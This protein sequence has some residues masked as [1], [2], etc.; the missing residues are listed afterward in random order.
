MSTMTLSMESEERERFDGHQDTSQPNLRAG[1][2][3]ERSWEVFEREAYLV[4]GIFGVSMLIDVFLSGFRDSNNS[5]GGGVLGLIGLIVYG[6]M[7]A[8]INHAL[9]RLMRKEKVEFERIFKG[10]FRFWPAAGVSILSWTFMA[11]GFVCLLVPGIIIG[12]GLIP[13]MY[14]VLEEHRGVKDTLSRAWSLTQGHKMS[15]GKLIAVLVIFNFGGLLLCGVGV[16]F[17]GAFSTLVFAAAYDEL[18]QSSVSSM[19]AIDDSY[20]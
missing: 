9:V 19:D 10:F 14:L 15:L 7:K 1:H 17:T 20:I 5:G 13:C 12:L 2:L 4:V 11:L 8:G 3:F 16:I 18:Y 6:P